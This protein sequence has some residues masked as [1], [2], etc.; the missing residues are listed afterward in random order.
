[1]CG[2]IDTFLSLIDVA[3]QIVANGKL[4]EHRLRSGDLP[5]FDTQTGQDNG[6]LGSITPQS[7]RKVALDDTFSLVVGG[8]T[9]G[10]AVCLERRK[11]LGQATVCRSS[12]AQDLRVSGQT[13]VVFCSN[14]YISVL[15][16]DT[17]RIVYQRRGSSVAI[18]QD[19]QFKVV[20]MRNG[21]LRLKPLVSNN[22]ETLYSSA[23]ITNAFGSC[24]SQWL[25]RTFNN[26][27]FILECPNTRKY[28]VSAFVRNQYKA[29]SSAGHMT[30]IQG[31]N[32]AVVR[33]ERSLTYYWNDFNSHCII[34]SPSILPLNSTVV[35][36]G[37]VNSH[38]V[39]I[40]FINETVYAYDTGRG[41]R[42]EYLL[43]L[44]SLTYPCIHGNCDGYYITKDGYLAIVDN[45]TSQDSYSLKL[46]DL[47]NVTAGSY[48]VANLQVLPDVMSIYYTTQILPDV[49]P[50][51][52]SQVIPEPSTA[53]SSSSSTPSSH[54]SSPFSS[55]TVSNLETSAAVT[56]SVS[57]SSTVLHFEMP[58]PVLNTLEIILIIG[59]VI[60]GIAVAIFVAVAVVLCC[61]MRKRHHKSSPTDSTR[62]STVTVN[63]SEGA[64]SQESGITAIAMQEE[65]GQHHSN[66]RYDV[67]AKSEVESPD[68]ASCVVNNRV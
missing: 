25:H 38:T 49:D 66:Y 59:T 5:W 19:D 14:G 2:G 43:P 33:G 21:G 23:E 20:Y 54:S 58:H 40:L 64:S 52:S 44:P 35:D 37:E 29:I 28:V 16:T 65:Q 9:N 51:L 68:S 18:L 7:R 46:Y 56:T 60:G 62:G 22:Y 57:P 13:A 30:V 53:S 11:V 67:T 4:Q 41:C 34:N 45:G 61:Y 42:D 17:C 63:V 55:T 3:V 48:P 8:Q 26:S 39:L 6:S 32:E 36:Y 10:L 15:S 24:P 50:V 12:P 47:R 1:M 27:H 31:K